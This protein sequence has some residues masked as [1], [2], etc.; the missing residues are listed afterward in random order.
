MEQSFQAMVQKRGTA[1]FFS[2]LLI[3]TSAGVK[4]NG[5]MSTEPSIVYAFGVRSLWMATP[6]IL[7]WDRLGDG[8]AGSTPA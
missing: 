7:R 3:Q 2:C 4:K 8:I 5:T 1:S 6:T